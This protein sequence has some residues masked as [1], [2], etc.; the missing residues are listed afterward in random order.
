MHHWY[1]GIGQYLP[2]A[3]GAVGL[4]WALAGA[5][6]VWR[7]VFAQWRRLLLYAFYVLA[8]SASTVV[9]IRPLL[10][11]RYLV[12]VPVVLAVTAIALPA[13]WVKK[14]LTLQD[15]L[16]GMAGAGLVLTVVAGTA[17]LG[18]HQGFAV[19][20]GHR[21]LLAW[22]WPFANKNTLGMLLVFSVPSA[23]GLALDRELSPGVRRIWAAVTL[24]TL[25][26]VFFSYARSAWI[27]VLVA[28]VLLLVVRLGRR[29]VW[30]V[31]G[32]L[33]V[34]GV[35]AV[36]ATGL[37]RWEHLWAHGLSGRLG[38]WQAALNVLVKRPW[39]GVGP[40]NSPLAIRPYVP[41]AYAGLSPHD[42]LLR[43]AVELGLVGLAL[44]TAIVLGGLYGLFLSRRA[45][46]NW[47][48]WVLGAVALAS[49]AQQMVE[50]LLFGGV[51][52]GDFFFTVLISLGW[53]L[54]VLPET[55]YLAQ[56]KRVPV[57]GK[58]R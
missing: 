19:P 41:A 10:S 30:T 47:T 23:L 51:S 15:V 7:L 44:W 56:W 36:A 29:G 13:L 9:S 4:L 48:F 22:E 2:F 49:L 34:F 33:A 27:A 40:G 46:R 3:G 26:G 58:G 54:P 37:K 38:L 5:P 57:Q 35:L 53:M 17:A 21:Q 45:H 39:F 1:Q 6:E 31:A 25:A 28:L 8:V 42:T 24:V 11:L 52:F 50:S 12:G 43:T 16:A 14:W 18:F 20:V 32:G 55:A